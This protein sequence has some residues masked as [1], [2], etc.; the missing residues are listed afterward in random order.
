[1]SDPPSAVGRVV[2]RVG[3]WG[4]A[5][6]ALLLTAVTFLPLRHAGYIQDDHLAVEQNEIVARG[7]LAE[8]FGSYYWAGARGADK[9][10]YRPI[11]IWSYA[12]ERRTVG[13]PGPAVAHAVNVLLHA[14][15]SIVLMLLA[16]RLGTG[17]SAAAAAMLLFAVHPVHVEAVGSIVARA[18]ILAA[19]FSLLAL[20]ALTHAGPWAGRQGSP[21]RQRLAAWGAAAALFLALGSKEGALVTPV[22]MVLLEISFR[23]PPAGRWRPWLVER[24]A[25][26]VP[27][28]LAVQLYLVLRIRALE[29]F[30][31]QGPHPLDNH[32]VLLDGVERLATALGLVVR[33]LWLLLFPVNL[34]I[35]YSGHVIPV[36][37][38]IWAW[39]PLLGL[40]LLAG[41]LALLLA[42]FVRRSPWR[43]SLAPREP[44]GSWPVV[45]LAAGLFLLPY[46]IVGNLLTDVGTIFAERLL[47]FPSTGFCLLFGVVLSRLAWTY[48]AFP[49]WSEVQRVRLIGVALTIL[50]GAFCLQSWGRALAWRDD[51]TVFAAAVRSHPESPRA[52]FIVG[53]AHLE[54]GREDEALAAF[55]RTLA[56]WPSHVPALIERG[57]ILG[58]R[59]RFAAA[60]AAYAEALLHAPGNPLALLNLGI[61]LHR[62]GRLAEAERALRKATLTRSGPD[63]EP[64]PAGAKAWAQLGHIR[65]D[66]GRFGRA[67]EAYRMAIDL[68]RDDLRSR[69]REAEA[70]SGRR[71]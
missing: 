61:A 28:A 35:D 7:D 11:A 44:A 12:L 18:E 27:S 17:L 62:Q 63:G 24:A 9:S 65:F 5:G 43:L 67:A 56:L 23:A 1:V 53:K 16:L 59:G 3:A 51:A 52:H 57:T 71:R 14:G 49:T 50:L 2:R 68:G 60:E 46:L 55:D 19:G 29:G 10:L 34:S 13:E 6:L 25:A 31:L 32:L 21:G 8:I 41:A 36:E 20:W 30:P 47:Y 70:R 66:A 39:R 45:S 15:V 69:L 33:T 64:L 26:L 22:L 37:S 40:L 54:S 42:R 58:K 48:P 38:G 4:A